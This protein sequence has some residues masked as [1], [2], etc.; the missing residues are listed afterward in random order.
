MSV[1]VECRDLSV[2]VEDTA[3]LAPTSFCHQA[4]GLIAL[5]G[6]NGSGKTT[7]LKTLAGRQLPT[8]G[9]CLIDGQT[10][11]EFD[12][13]FRAT[14]ASLIDT[15]P[16]ARDMT[17]LEQLALVR[18]SWGHDDDAFG[19]AQQFL[20]RLTIAQLAERFPFELSAGQL[21]LFA[22][23]LTLSRPS[24]LLLLDEPERHLD[25]E[26]V[27]ALLGVVQERVQAGALVITATHRAE[28]IAHT[29]SQ[30]ELEHSV[31]AV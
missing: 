9:Q 13:G 21:Q 10:P 5:T 8:S 16:I 1:R 3:L 23:A 26:R 2:V 30:I 12:P 4:P 19:A 18:V 11:Y 28:L 22:V 31:S 6:P 20:D 17:L 7:L 14:V 27:H 15:P 29:D 24:S 25:G